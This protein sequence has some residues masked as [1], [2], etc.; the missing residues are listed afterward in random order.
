MKPALSRG[1]LNVIGATT[2]DEYREDRLAKLTRERG[3]KPEFGARPL[4]RTIQSELDNK[5]A[6][7]LLSGDTNPGDT[8]VA[9]EAD[10]HLVCSVRH[11]REAV[12]AGARS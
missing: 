2:I 6:S 10:D 12:G 9:D 3:Y 4:R 1:E 7:L 8:I 5:V 11:G